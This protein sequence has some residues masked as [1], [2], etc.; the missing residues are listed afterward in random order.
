MMQACGVSMKQRV[1]APGLYPCVPRVTML[2]I[3]PWKCCSSLQM[4]LSSMSESGG[5]GAVVHGAALGCCVLD[6]VA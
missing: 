6:R 1:Q 3:C 5:P 2:W 4:V